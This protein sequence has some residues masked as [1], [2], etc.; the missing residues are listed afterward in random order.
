MRKALLRRKPDTGGRRT[1]A[2]LAAGA[3]VLM[4]VTPLSIAG[5][6]VDTEPGV[7]DTRYI[8]LTSDETA[9]ADTRRPV[10]QDSEEGTCDTHPGGLMIL[11]K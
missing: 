3:G 7:C 6:A 2:Q 8:G 9:V 4:A 10:W 1:L 11:V 5:V